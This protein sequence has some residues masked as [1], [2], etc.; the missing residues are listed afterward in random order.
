MINISVTSLQRGDTVCSC[1]LVE[2]VDQ[3]LFNWCR[4]VVFNVSDVL[5]FGGV[6]GNLIFDGC[7]NL[8]ETLIEH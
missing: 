8:Q 6:I 2:E 1:V 3:R 5:I 7:E 4:D